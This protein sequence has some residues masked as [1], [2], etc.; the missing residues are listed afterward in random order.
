MKRIFYFIN[1]NKKGCFEA[2][3]VL[4]RWCNKNGVETYP[5]E[6]LKIF[7]GNLKNSLVISFGGDGTMLS[8][9]KFAITHSLPIMGVNL[10]S[11]GFLSNIRES[12]LESRLDMVKNKKFFLQSCNLLSTK[13]NGRELIGLN[14]IVMKSQDIHRMIKIRVFLDG[15]EISTISA[16]G[17]IISTPLG[18]TAYSLASGG[19]IVYPDIDAFLITPI[20]PHLL[21]QRPILVKSSS[22]ITL[23]PISKNAIIFADSQKVLKVAENQKVVLTNY[24]KKIKLIK[25]KDFDLFDILKEKFHLGKDPRI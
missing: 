10:G 11:L 1:K 22:K 3:D 15:K 25:F 6:T 8:A 4:K 18:S 7:K 24:S 2:V 9:A 14:D 20:C 16:D 5:I 23:V 13:V 21:V 19:P 12:E 17:V